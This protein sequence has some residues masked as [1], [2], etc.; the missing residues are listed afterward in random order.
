M[1][2]ISFGLAGT[3]T[4]AVLGTVFGTMMVVNGVYKCHVQRVK[5]DKAA[6]LL[7]AKSPFITG[8]EAQNAALASGSV[9]KDGTIRDLNAENKKLVRDFKECHQTLEEKGKRIEAGELEISRLQASL[10]T[11]QGKL[12]IKGVLDDDT[13]VDPQPD[14]AEAT[15]A[16]ADPHAEAVV[17]REEGSTGGADAT[18]R[19]GQEGGVGD[20]FDVF[21]RNFVTNATLTA[22][23]FKRIRESV[24]SREQA[25]AQGDSTS[26]LGRP[27]VAEGQTAQEAFVGS[28][29]EVDSTAGADNAQDN[30]EAHSGH[31]TD[32]VG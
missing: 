14:G 1:T 17:E 19:Q 21:G 29:E 7:S 5:S 10:A 28:D 24:T 8:L 3:I 6:Q 13:V 32:S 26:S 23:Q 22:E 30:V 4:A 27:N 16:G 20:V 15:G 2:F 11:V 12:G 18:G 25:E 9:A 31:T